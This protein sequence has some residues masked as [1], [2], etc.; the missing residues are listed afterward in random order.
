MA[1]AVFPEIRMRKRRKDEAARMKYRQTRAISL[2]DLIMPIFVKE[3]ISGKKAIASMPGIYQF[4]VRKIAGEAGAIYRSGIP[5]VIL[6]GI[7]RHK[8]DGGSSSYEETGVVQQA[9]REI[10]KE[11]PGLSVIADVCMCE[12][13]SHGHCGIVKPIIGSRLSVI[14]KKSRRRPDAGH[15]TPIF[16]VDNDA[17]I[18]ILARISLSYANAGADIVAPSAMM[19]GQV[20]A[21]KE[22]LKKGGYPGVKIMSYSAKY[23]SSF[24]APF[25]D[26]AESP[27]QFGDRLTYQMDYHN[28]D[29]ALLE[30]R[31]DIGEGADML[32][33]K[34]ALGY[35][36]IIYRM[37]KELDFPLA[38]YSVSGEYS[39][40][41]AAAMKG[42][43]DERKVALEALTGLKRAGADQII[44]YYAEE[45][46]GWMESESFD[47][48]QD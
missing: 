19:D 2:R 31:L 41:K 10:K 26:A 15:R 39:M 23:A 48:A 35:A 11:A 12:Y 32:M 6:F 7:P 25:R 13:T 22:A 9:I 29:E 5:A 17:T 24:Y 42:Y 3:G 28:S 44:T 38:C 27:P 30:A 33:V 21:I 4:P 43:I 16:E 37:K 46:A 47:K 8:D 45:V 20:K 1:D 34:P 14:G 36:D 18:E 40:I